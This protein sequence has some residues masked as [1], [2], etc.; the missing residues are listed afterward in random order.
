MIHSIASSVITAAPF[1]RAFWAPRTV[2]AALLIAVMSL[3]PTQANAAGLVELVIDRVMVAMEPED[4]GVPHGPQRPPTMQEVLLDTCAAHGYGEDCAKILLGM[5]SVETDFKGTAIGDRGRARGWFQIW[6]KLH[7]RSLRRVMELRHPEIVDPVACAE[8]LACAADW[9]IV[10]LE[11][12]GYP[13]HVTYA[14]QCHNGCNIDNGYA[15]K[16]LRRAAYHW[17]REATL[18]LATN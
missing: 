12:N 16:V 18:A 6:P 7:D 9:T 11:S 15:R 13:K 1:L 4:E 10:Y 5:A 2:V 17:D 14:V 3:Q 8:D